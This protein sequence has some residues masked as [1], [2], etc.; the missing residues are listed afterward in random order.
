MNSKKRS[1]RLR[2]RQK[3][4]LKKRNPTRRK[5]RSLSKKFLPNPYPMMHTMNV[6]EPWASAIA[7]GLKKYEGRPNIGKIR[8]MNVGDTIRFTGLKSGESFTK[9]IIGKHDFSTF[10]EMIEQCGLRHILPGIK[11]IKKGV[12]IYH[13]FPEYPKKEALY[14]VVAIELE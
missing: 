14:G 3:T 5:T 4:S 13:S 2:S 12:E 10:H 6:Q 8:T 9:K 11:T 1:K 7:S